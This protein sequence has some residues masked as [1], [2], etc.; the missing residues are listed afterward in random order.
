MTKKPFIIRALLLRYKFYRVRLIIVILLVVMLPAVAFASG[1]ASYQILAQ[2]PGKQIVDELATK[3][4]AYWFLSLAVAAIASWT[5]L[6]SWMIKQLDKQ[7]TANSDITSK[8]IGYM[9]KDHT[10]TKVITTQAISMLDKSIVILNIA[11]DKLNTQATI[12]PII[13]PKN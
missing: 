13:K 6:F 7:R 12:S 3:N 2:I 11:I 8:L 4:I 10:D 5:W 1:I 9:E